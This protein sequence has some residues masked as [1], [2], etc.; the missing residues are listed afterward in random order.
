MSLFYLTL[1]DISAAIF[2]LRAASIFRV[3]SKGQCFEYWTV[4]L[5][6]SSFLELQKIRQGQNEGPA[7]CGKWIC[8]LV[9]TF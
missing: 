7:L 1:S 2:N 9:C 3:D 8:F 4:H 6:C 5:E